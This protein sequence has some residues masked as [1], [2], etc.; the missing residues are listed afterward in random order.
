MVEEGIELQL[1]IKAKMM[2]TEL[3]K[4]WVSKEEIEPIKIFNTLDTAA[5][6]STEGHLSSKRSVRLRIY[7]GK[8]RPRLFMLWQSPFLCMDVK[9]GQWKKLTER[10]VDSF[11]VYC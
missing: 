11:E 4:L 10:K 1:N 9:T 6:K 5:K 2:A 7:H 3:Y 8:L